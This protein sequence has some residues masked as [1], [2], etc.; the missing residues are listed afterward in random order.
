[1][2]RNQWLD[3]VRCLHCE[4]HWYVAVD[5]VDDDY[6]FR[7]L[8]MREVEAIRKDDVWPT[9]FDDFVNVWPNTSFQAL[10][11]RLSSPWRGEKFDVL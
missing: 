10:Q 3:L 6:Y 9:D 8:S 11:A 2:A 1:V 7:R 5:T 4:Q